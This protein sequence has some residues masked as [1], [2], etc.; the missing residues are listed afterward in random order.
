MGAMPHRDEGARLRRFSISCI[1][2]VTALVALT[3]AA[4][5]DADLQLGSVAPPAGAAPE[6]CPPDVVVIQE[7][8][9][10]NISY[11]V[12]VG[13][14]LLTRWELNVAS[15]GG[16]APATL[17]VLRPAGEGTYEILATDTET[18]PFPPPPGGVSSFTLASPIAVDAGDTFAI[19]SEAAGAVCYF[20]G[21]ATPAADTLRAIPASEPPAPGRTLPT[22]GAKSPAGF[23][24]NLAVRIEDEQDLGVTTAASPADVTVGALAVLG[25]TVTNHGPET[26]P[27]TFTDAVPAGLTVGTALA[28]GGSCSTAGQTVS[29]KIEGLAV[30]QSAPVDILVT[31]TAAGSYVNTVS[32]APRAGIV[33]PSPADDSASAR[34]D[35]AARTAST[36]TETAPDTTARTGPNTRACI[37]PSLRQVKLGSARSLLGPLGCT[38]GKVRH[39]HN[40]KVAKGTV[41]RTSPRPGTYA[42]GRR[43]GL[44]V[45][46]G[47]PRHRR[48]ARA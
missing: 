26:G 16:G 39:V 36:N 32:V 23:R 45:S 24:M 11:I 30:G 18:P 44:V 28:G 37:V 33:D 35:V 48:H 31:P 19:F 4:A 8:A 12:P 40:R 3:C 10:P 41:V 13:G 9:D 43:V 34:L 2:M 38:A 1:C 20:H 15:G 21:G 27:V 42:A 47:P 5:A 22:G 46:S 29:C 25:S 6:S 17:V 7:T 14:G